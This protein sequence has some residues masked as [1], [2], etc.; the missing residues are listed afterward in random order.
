M[1]HSGNGVMTVLQFKLPETI[2]KQI[3]TSSFKKNCNIR[4]TFKLKLGC[5]EFDYFGFFF[6]NVHASV[7]FFK[8]SGEHIKS[9]CC[10]STVLMK[11]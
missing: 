2:H 8:V 7:L 5:V 1:R 3:H 4:N 11:V 10:P 6:I 9:C